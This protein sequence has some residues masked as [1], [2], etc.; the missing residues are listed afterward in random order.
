MTN[1]Y[2]KN[3][4][5]NVDKILGYSVPFNFI[6]GGRGTGKTYGALKYMVETGVKTMVMRRTQSQTDLINKQEF[7]PINPVANDLKKDIKVKTISKYSASITDQTNEENKKVL[8]YTCA[9]S[10]ISN[11]RGFDTSDI[12]L[13][14]YDE[15]IPEQH[16]RLIKNEGGA[17]LNAYE[18]INRNRELKGEKPLQVLCLANSNNIANPLFIELGLV[19]RVR[20]MMCKG[21]DLLIDRDRGILVALSTYSTISK[22]KKDTALY[23][24]SA[25]SEFSGMAIDNEFSYNDFENIMPKPLK[26]FTPVCIVGDIAVYKH[27]DR[28]E[29]YISSHRSGSPPMYG[30]DKTGLKKYRSHYGL[31]LQ[32]AYMREQVFFESALTKSLFELYTI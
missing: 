14:I 25:D 22:Q 32:S 18:T 16:E 2:H 15:F 26:E 21:N 29:Y 6:I 7:S 30:S 13:L 5:I 28:R 8:G 4:Y 17:F 11:M 20:K 10:T 3:G 24:V 23:K 1:I 31:R 19:D 27:K 9:L 12:K